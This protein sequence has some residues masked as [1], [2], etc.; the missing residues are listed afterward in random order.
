M[1][2]VGA[3]FSG[4]GVLS[5][6]VITSCVISERFRAVQQSLFFVQAWC[7]AAGSILGPAALGWWLA[8]SERIGASWRGAY[9]FTAAV[10]GTL[11]LWPLFLRRG[12]L[13]D[14]EMP[15]MPAKGTPSS[16]QVVLAD[17]AIYV[18]CLLTIL[19]SIPEAGMVAFVGQL[20]QKRLGIGVAEA[21]YFLSANSLGIFAGRSLLTWIT[22]Y[23]RIPDLL[24]FAV[25]SAGTTLALAATIASP[26]YWW[27]LVL[28]GLSGAFFSGTG[29]AISSYL[30]LR[31]SREVST[32]YS[33]MAGIS[34]VGGAAGPYLIGYM[35]THWSLERGIW[36]M[37]IVDLLLTAGAVA[38]YRSERSSPAR[39]DC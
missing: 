12:N 36:S 25:C 30:G 33:L 21:A 13:P 22:V 10:L 6:V 17:P 29:P 35:G 24:V 14:K 19:K 2:L 37:P 9:Y 4:L 38:W 1:V 34:Y 20:Y 7:G 18:I 15:K 31:F 39:P 16:L 26:G 5:L 32:A 11:A 28:F 27:A 23:R 8:Y 3:F